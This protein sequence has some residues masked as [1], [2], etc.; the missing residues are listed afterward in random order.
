MTRPSRLFQARCL[1]THG[2]IVA[3]SAGGNSCSAEFELEDYAGVKLRNVSSSSRAALLYLPF[4]GAENHSRAV[5]WFGGSEGG[6]LDPRYPALLAQQT[7]LPILNVAYF[8]CASFCC[9]RLFN[10]SIW[11]ILSILFGNI[12]PLACSGV[13]L[14]INSHISAKL[15]RSRLELAFGAGAWVAR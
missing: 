9:P 5:L 3:E 6:L 11:S 14:F 15:F 10:T 8:G 13:L 7:Q 4:D 1:R 12:C 2:K